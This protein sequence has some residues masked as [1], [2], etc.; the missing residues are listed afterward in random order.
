MI[1]QTKE[2]GHEGGSGDVAPLYGL[3]NS[4][5]PCHSSKLRC[6]REKPT[7]ARCKKNRTV[8]IYSPT[9]PP[10]RRRRVT[11]VSSAGQGAMA[12]PSYLTN[13]T[14][15]DKTGSDQTTLAD[16][17]EVATPAYANSHPTNPAS[18]WDALHTVMDNEDFER[19]ISGLDSLDPSA[20]LDTQLSNVDLLATPINN[21][22]LDIGGG[23]GAHTTNEDRWLALDPT[24]EGFNIPDLVTAPGSSSQSTDQS[25]STPDSSWL[26][27]SMQFSAEC[28]SLKQ[29][30]SSSRPLL[31]FS[32]VSEPQDLTDVQCL[33][34]SA[35][36]N[37][38]FHSKSACNM[39]PAVGLGACLHME[40]LLRWT[41]TIHKGCQGCR[42]DELVKFIV[43]GVTNQVVGTFR[44]IIDDNAKGLH[45]GVRSVAHS[46]NR[47][48]DMRPQEET[49]RSLFDW[50]SLNFGSKSIH[51]AAKIT[52]LRRLMGL[53]LR[54]IGQLLED[55]VDG[56]GSEPGKELAQALRVLIS[57]ISERLN[58]TTGML[59]TLE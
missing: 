42:N 12:N 15:V 31:L 29:W 44:T 20:M 39:Q 23:D 49:Q 50:T 32:N 47:P 4:C 51:G 11:T 34:Y 24:S 10:G 22:A 57:G 2:P 52:F 16:S 35:V 33:C 3:R 7:C 27:N 17:Q 26:S 45:G 13:A 43:A 56:K 38:Q 37:L 40:R 41:W 58:V 46:V 5:D 53:K 54:Q 8:C 14:R 25:F 55:L 9:K 28:V 30:A 6:S 48:L 19:Y 59:S 1:S 18:Q 36:A 21:T